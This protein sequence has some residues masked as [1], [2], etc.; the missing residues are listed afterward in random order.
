MRLIILTAS[1]ILI[2]IS[3]FA[4]SSNQPS[5]EEIK[6]IL[7]NQSISG[8]LATGH[9]CPCP[10]LQ[11]KTGKSCGAKSA[12]S[13]PGGKLPLCYP[14]DVTPEMIMQYRESISLTTNEITPT[15]KVILEEQNG[16]LM[17]PILDPKTGKYTVDIT[18]GKQIVEQGL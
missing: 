1:L 8:Y 15:R 16:S 13:K 14:S 6:E 7:I 5:D 12:W 10:N 17:F 11:D 2:P 4:A 18:R 3:V 9:S